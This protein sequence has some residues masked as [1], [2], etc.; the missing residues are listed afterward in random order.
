MICDDVITLVSE[1]PGDHGVFDTYTESKRTVFCQV[2]SV[3]QSEWW[4]AKSNGLHPEFVFRISDKADYENE[5]I[6]I[7]NGVRYRVV[8]ANIVVSIP[9]STRGID[10]YPTDSQMVDLTVERI[11]V[12][13]VA[14]PAEVTS[15]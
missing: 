8:R 9:N 11:T 10:S 13:A 3:S 12:D 1:T 4:S 15:T 6:C 14:P 2:R 5:K 7:Y